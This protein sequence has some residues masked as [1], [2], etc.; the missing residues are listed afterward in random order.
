MSHSKDGAISV[1]LKETRSMTRNQAQPLTN[2]TP[3]L[4][5]SA[6]DHLA[7][8]LHKEAEGLIKQTPIHPDEEEHIMVKCL[9]QG[10]IIDHRDLNSHYDDMAIEISC[11]PNLNKHWWHFKIMDFLF[12][13]RALDSRC[14]LWKKKKKKEKENRLTMESHSHSRREISTYAVSEALPCT[15]PWKQR[16]KQIFRKF[17]SF[18]F[19]LPGIPLTAAATAK[20]PLIIL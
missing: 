7:M 18:Q 11:P 4:E 20:P 3:E 8:T 12:L 9:A 5:S 14:F 6:L 10:R 15:P 16:K 13:K 2:K 17:I 19:Y 1:L